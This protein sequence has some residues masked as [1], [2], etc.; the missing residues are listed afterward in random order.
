MKIWFPSTTLKRISQ[1]LSNNE[2]M[3]DFI[4]VAVEER[5]NKLEREKND[6]WNKNT[7]KRS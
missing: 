4:I 3:I 5:L 1:V 2:T 7:Q 6:R